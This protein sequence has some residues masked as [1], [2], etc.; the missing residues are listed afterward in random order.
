[1]RGVVL[2]LLAPLCGCAMGWPNGSYVK[3][4]GPGDADVL[5]PAV[6]SY[7]ARSVRAGTMVSVIPADA[8]PALAEAIEQD[9]IRDGL[10]VGLSGQAVGYVVTPLNDGLLLR[11]TFGDQ[12]G[13]RLYV[14]DPAG[15]LVPAGPMMEAIFA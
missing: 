7:V 6:A 3:A 11:V 9:L 4:V 8:D 10:Q 2:A 15:K 12:V 5:S 1:M 13:S 14:R